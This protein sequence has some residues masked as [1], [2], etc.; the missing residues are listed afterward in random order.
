MRVR[1]KSPELRFIHDPSA[2]IYHRVPRD[3]Q[4]VRYLLS[5]CSA[6][7]R[8]KANL[9]AVSYGDSAHPL[10]REVSYLTQTV[11]SGVAFSVSQFLR[12]D[13]WALARAALLIVAVL[14]TIL[15]YEITRI[16]N[17]L[18]KRKR[19]LL[20]QRVLVDQRPGTRVSGSSRNRQ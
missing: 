9:R 12:G 5:R 18:G 17:M 3:R 10:A 19:E 16:R 15:A 1:G 6:E 14:N 2:V 8:S 11:P 13:S 7:G 4:R 20:A